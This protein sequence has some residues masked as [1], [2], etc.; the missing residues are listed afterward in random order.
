MVKVPLPTV[1]EFCTVQAEGRLSSPPFSLSTFVQSI[2]VSP[3]LPSPLL[4]P[5][6]PGHRCFCLSTCPG[7]YF[8]CQTVFPFDHPP[9][10]LFIII[11]PSLSSVLLFHVLYFVCYSVQP[12]LFLH[13]ILLPA[14]FLFVCLV[15]SVHPFILSTS[16]SSPSFCL[17]CCPVLHFLCPSVQSFISSIPV[18]SF[19][20]SVHL[21][22]FPYF[23]GLSIQSFRSVHLCPVFRGSACPSVP[24]L[25]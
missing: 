18:L 20:L 21:C 1:N 6:L 7:I 16:L 5:P 12:I 2:T 4:C 22:P 24:S 14:V 25:P 9:S 13:P 17:H 8:V 3:C 10:P 19:I 15:P 23:F 11:Y